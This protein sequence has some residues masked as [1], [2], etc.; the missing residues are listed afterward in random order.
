MS[1][2]RQRSAVPP[3]TPTFEHC[4]LLRAVAVPPGATGPV[5]ICRTPRPPAPMLQRMMSVW[6][7]R[8]DC[9][10]FD[11]VWEAT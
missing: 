5:A 2:R 8:C 7:T 6:G 10:Y 4:T 1:A 9:G 11:L 3:G